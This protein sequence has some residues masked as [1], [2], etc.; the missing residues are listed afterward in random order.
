MSYVVFWSAR[1]V[2]TK[3][4]KEVKEKCIQVVYITKVLVHQF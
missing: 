4:K 1:L 3:L 2:E